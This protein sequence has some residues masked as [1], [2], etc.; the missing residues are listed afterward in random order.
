MT[1]YR[2]AQWG[3]Q[4][5]PGVLHTPCDKKKRTIKNKPI[6]VM[7][8]FSSLLCGFCNAKNSGVLSSNNGGLRSLQSLT[9]PHRA[10]PRTALQRSTTRRQPANHT[11]QRAFDAKLAR[12]L[13]N[14]L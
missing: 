11:D 14:S 3:K 13:L 1:L 7:C 12:S 8:K 10:T 6:H 9:T 2:A 5:T 4:A